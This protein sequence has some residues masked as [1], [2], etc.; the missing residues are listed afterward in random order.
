MTRRDYLLLSQALGDAWKAADDTQ[1]VGVAFA[2]RALS[3]T[4]A[5]RNPKFD[6][7]LFMRNVCENC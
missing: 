7:T 4:L 5:A 6:Q 3:A 2:A 1:R